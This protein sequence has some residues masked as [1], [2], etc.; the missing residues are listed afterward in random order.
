MLESKALQPLPW[1][2]RTSEEWS[3]I[4]KKRVLR[5]FY[6]AAHAASYEQTDKAD[7]P[8]ALL[9]PPTLIDRLRLT[10]AF[11][12]HYGSIFPVLREDLDEMWKKDH[13]HLYNPEELNNWQRA[14]E[15]LFSDIRFYRFLEVS[16]SVRQLQ[17][18]EE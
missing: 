12:V 11:Q 18:K 5:L 3:Q 9:C 17:K 6:A 10:S 15:G 4:P 16:D 14:L 7:S 13:T 2:R 1:D 8:E